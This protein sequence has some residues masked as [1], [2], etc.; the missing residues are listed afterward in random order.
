[1]NVERDG[2]CYRAHIADP[3][4]GGAIR[5]SGDGREN[6]L[7]GEPTGEF[8]HLLSDILNGLVDADLSIRGVWESPW[9][10]QR[11]L[12]INLEP[13][14]EEHRARYIPYGLSVVARQARYL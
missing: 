8:R 14:S 10:G 6:I 2:R 5:V 4:V 7:E 12:D 13:G 9:P 1:V 11:T 3:Y